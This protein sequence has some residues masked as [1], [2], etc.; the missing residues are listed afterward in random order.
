[1]FQ[2]I[3]K[4]LWD[5]PEPLRFLLAGGLNTAVG[6]LIFATG[7]FLLTVPMRSLGGWIGDHYYVIIQW[8][9]WVISVPFGAFTFKYYAFQSKGAYLPQAL[10][11]YVVYFPAQLLASVLIVAF[12][13]LFS[14]WLP[15]LSNTIYPV[16]MTVLLAQFC[17]IFFSTIVSYFGHKYFTFRST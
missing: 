11:S 3:K 4:Y 6:Y 13:R 14:T 1:M 17:T 9:M 7:L 16:D 15:H 10:R 12:V 5:L 8:L 2:S